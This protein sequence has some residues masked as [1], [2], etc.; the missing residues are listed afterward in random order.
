MLGADWMV[1]PFDLR[2]GMTWARLRRRPGHPERPPTKPSQ[3]LTP[4]ETIEGF[5]THAAL[6]VSEEHIS[7]QVKAGYRADLTAF[8]EDPEDCDV[9]NLVDLPTLMTMVDEEVVYGGN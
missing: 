2:F 9:E 4:L 7:G 1:A 5:A 8:A 6:A 3:D